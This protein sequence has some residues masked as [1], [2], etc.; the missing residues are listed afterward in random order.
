MIPGRRYRVTI[1][2]DG[3]GDEGPPQLFA[4]LPRSCFEIGKVRSE[5]RSRIKH[6]KRQSEDAAWNKRRIR[7][8][9]SVLRDYQKALGAHRR[10]R[11]LYKKLAK[12][13]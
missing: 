4:F 12:A 6:P 2:A 8:L 7:L 1:E 5:L 3:V 13:A 9:Q 11:S 10:A